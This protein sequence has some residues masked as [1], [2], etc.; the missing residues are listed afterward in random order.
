MKSLQRSSKGYRRVQRCFEGFKDVSRDVGGFEEVQRASK[1]C[2]MTITP[3]SRSWRLDAM[4]APGWG[5]ICRGEMNVFEAKVV[6]Q[7]RGTRVRMVEISDSVG[8]VEVDG[9]FP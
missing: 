1:G 2:P 3:P 7:A 6:D 8:G 5:S 4:G 9:G